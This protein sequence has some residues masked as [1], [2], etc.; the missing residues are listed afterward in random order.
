MRRTTPVQ[1]AVQLERI[2]RGGVLALASVEMYICGIPVTLQGLEL[3]AAW[4]AFYACICR[5]SIIPAAAVSRLSGFMTTSRAES[6]A[7]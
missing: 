4:T 2:E 1:L 5:C 3:G 7:R 6:S